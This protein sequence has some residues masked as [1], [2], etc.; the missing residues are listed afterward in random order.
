IKQALGAWHTSVKQC[1]PYIRAELY[2]IPAKLI[3]YRL[4]QAFKHL[5]QRLTKCVPTEGH[6][7]KLDPLYKKELIHTLTAC[8]KTPERILG[9]V[10]RTPE[11]AKYEQMF[12]QLGLNT[13]FAQAKRVHEINVI[14]WIETRLNPLLLTD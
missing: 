2:T 14:T 3:R 7:F 4:T 9:S 8:Y 11:W 5:E 10:K 1:I 13:E 6:L 12:R